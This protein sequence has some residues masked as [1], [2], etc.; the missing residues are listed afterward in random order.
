[1]NGHK[2]PRE[3]EKVNKDGS[4]IRL[5]IPGGWVTISRSYY[6]MNGD[7][8]CAETQQTIWDKDMTH[9]WDLEN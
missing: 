2:S 6:L 4:F 5:R 1:M 9:P 8:C 3:F 7:S